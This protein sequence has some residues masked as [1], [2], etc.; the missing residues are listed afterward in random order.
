MIVFSAVVSGRVDSGTGAL[1]EASPVF[2]FRR[3]PSVINS[4]HFLLKRLRSA[5]FDALPAAC[6]Y[7]SAAA[8]ACF[9]AS[10][11]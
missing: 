3:S 1:G 11:P 2:A 5:G 6:I 9:R 10:C 8:M 7:S 4:A